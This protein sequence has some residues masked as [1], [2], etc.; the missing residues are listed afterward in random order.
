MCFKPRWIWIRCDTNGA[1]QGGHSGAPVSTVTV[2]GFRGPF[3]V[4]SFPGSL[5]LCALVSLHWCSA[6]A[7][8]AH[9]KSIGLKAS[10]HVFHCD[11]RGQWRV[12][13]KSF[14]FALFHQTLNCADG[15]SF[16]N[17]FPFT[18]LWW[19]INCAH[20]TPTQGTSVN[21]ENQSVSPS[22]V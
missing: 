20:C 22:L 10:G 1:S 6:T 12:I 7:Q 11:L 2:S 21:S 17:D 15:S 4:C 5:C 13:V 8:C 3:S 14:D 16:F 9:Q 18:C 19:M